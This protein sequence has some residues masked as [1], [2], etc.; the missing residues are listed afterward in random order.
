MSSLGA[1]L[2]HAHLLRVVVGSVRVVPPLRGS[3]NISI[4]NNPGLAPWAMREYRPVGALLHPTPIHL[5][6]LMRLPSL[7]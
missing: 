4:T 2:Q 1:A 3:I 5:F 7:S 6:Y